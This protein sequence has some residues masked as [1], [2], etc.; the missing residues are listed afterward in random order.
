MV[1]HCGWQK[2]PLISETEKSGPFAGQDGAYLGFIL[3]SHP[4]KVS[5]R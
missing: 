2:S 5:F 4:W 1:D 3:A